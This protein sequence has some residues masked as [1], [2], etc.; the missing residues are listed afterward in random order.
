MKQETLAKIFT[1][2]VADNPDK[3]MHIYVFNCFV[4]LD[5]KNVPINHY[6]EAKLST[7]NM[8]KDEEPQRMTPARSGT[9]I[10]S[11]PFRLQMQTYTGNYM[12]HCNFVPYTENGLKK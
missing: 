3:Y 11:V 2:L 8:R 9:S 5:K 7:P 10:I 1:D 4:V 6:K 12:H